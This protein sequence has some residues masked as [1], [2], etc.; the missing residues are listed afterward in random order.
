LL[1]SAKIKREISRLYDKDPQGWKVLVGRDR[2]G[3]YD[4]LFSHRTKVWQVKEYQVNPY[5]FVG[6]GAKLRNIPEPALGMSDY[7][8]GLRPISGDLIKELTSAMDD[9]RTMNEIASKLLTERTVSSI[10][11]AQS[12]AI[13]QGP[14]FQSNRP[15]D[16]LSSAHMKLDEKLRREL[17]RIVNREFRHTVAPYI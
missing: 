17:R 3:F 14:I 8:F 11:A 2:V 16:S 15:L 1:D 5:K 12:P 10:E 6:L 13:L 7:P 9:P 4:I